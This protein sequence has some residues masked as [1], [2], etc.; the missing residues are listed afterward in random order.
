MRPIVTLFALLTLAISAP[1][2]AQVQVIGDS[3]AASCFRGVERNR[4]PLRTLDHCTTALERDVLAPRD[5]A[6]THV[7]RGIIQ[8]R[9]NQLDLAEADFSRAS[10]LDRDGRL[11]GAIAVNRSAVLLRQGR[12]SAALEQTDI[13]L[14][15]TGP[16]RA[17]AW[18]NRAVALEEMNDLTGAYHAYQE[19]QTLRPGWPAPARELARFSLDGSS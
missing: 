1:A 10:Q 3:A 13:A 16:H 17:D 11:T 8:L 5:R 19:A 15:E 2:A 14:A 9:R 4:A 12:V 18:F 6:A 7:N